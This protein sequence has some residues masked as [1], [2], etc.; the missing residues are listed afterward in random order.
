[1]SLLRS[2]E[3]EKIQTSF[4]SMLLISTYMHTFSY[5]E[6]FL[7]SKYYTELKYL[8][9]KSSRIVLNMTLKSSLALQNSIKNQ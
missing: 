5:Q 9:P 4:T 3:V 6:F 8:L 7:K 2:I 1:M